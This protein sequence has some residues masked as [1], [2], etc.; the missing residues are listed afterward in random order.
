L[1][2]IKPLEKFGA[3]SNPSSIAPDLAG[4]K[5]PILSSD[6]FDVNT[7]RRDFPILQERVN[8]RQLVWLDNAATT[9]KAAGGHRSSFLFLSARIIPISIRRGQHAGRREPPMRIEAAREK[10]RRFL[11]AGSTNE[12]IFRARSD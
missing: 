6:P 9:H 1:D 7:V 2:E 12:I 8:G 3:G 11:N 10:V 5:I 4:L